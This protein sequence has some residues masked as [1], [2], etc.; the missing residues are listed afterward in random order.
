MLNEIDLS[1]VDLNFLVLFQAVL[2]QRHVRKAAEQLN[3][4][5]SAVSHGLGRLRRLLNDPLFL[6]TPKGV[7]P[8]AR[9]TEL[10]APIADAL[11]R[12]KSII[13]SAA[14]F[15]PATSTRRFTIGAPD[16]I[17][18]VFLPP[19]FGRVW[20]TAPGIG[21]SVRQ[22]LATHAE[23][24]PHHA[25]RSAFADS[26]S[27]LRMPF[28]RSF[29]RRCLAGYGRPRPASASAFGSFWRRT[30]KVRRTT[31]G[32]RPSPNW[33][34]GRSTSRS[35]PP[36]IFRYAF[37]SERSVGRISSSPRGWGILSRTIQHSSDTATCNT[38]SSP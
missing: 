18:A 4:T 27:A 1:R 26:R 23:S 9:A 15:D 17:S 11:A 21:L 12:V 10:A 31:P 7:V 38:W 19:L 35:F 14:P 29:C 32:D 20:Q 36:T 28:Q 25:W 30:R 37:A 34:F 16:A 2:R 5:P 33:K 3:L 6:R 22:L 13:A 24:S 8:T